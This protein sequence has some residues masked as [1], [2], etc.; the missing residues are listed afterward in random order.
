MHHLESAIML[1]SLSRLQNLQNLQNLQITNKS[2]EDVIIRGNN[3]V[4]YCDIP[5]KG[6][7]QYKEGGFDYDKFYDWANDNPHPVYISEYDA[8]FAEVHAF[9]H[10]SSLSATNNKKKTVEKIFWNGN[11]NT[12]VTTLFDLTIKNKKSA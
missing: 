12:N 10:R 5:Y 6:T 1:E 11:G 2:Y 4:I 8:P 7:G 9:T 3:P